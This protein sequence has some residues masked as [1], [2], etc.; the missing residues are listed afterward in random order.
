MGIITSTQSVSHALPQASYAAQPANQINE[1]VV[2]GADNGS[3]TAFVSLEERLVDAY[4][5]LS[6][7]YESERT[8]IAKKAADPTVVTDLKELSDL[9]SRTSKYANNINLLSAL[10]RKGIDAI[11]TLMKL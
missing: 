5:S 2:L 1:S 9:S 7:S 4:A 11:S 3:S 10:A 6:S 8:S